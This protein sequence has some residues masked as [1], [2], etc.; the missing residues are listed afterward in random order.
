MQLNF[1]T[2]HYF[3]ESICT[4][5]SF[6][7]VI[8]LCSRNQNDSSVCSCVQHSQ[9]NKM[10]PAILSWND[11]I[12]RSNRSNVLNLRP[13]AQYSTQY[14]FDCCACSKLRHTH[15]Y[16]ASEW[17][18]FRE[19]FFHTHQQCLY[20]WCVYNLLAASSARYIA[21]FSVNYFYWFDSTALRQQSVF[22]AC[23]Y[24]YFYEFNENETNARLLLCFPKHCQFAFRIIHNCTCAIRSSQWLCSIAKVNDDFFPFQLPDWMCSQLCEYA[25]CI[26]T[27]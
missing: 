26:Q 17:R 13:C 20:A 2:L 3:G 18:Q 12:S 8:R 25:M 9:I 22:T 23:F 24:R 11:V 14:K 7:A 10:L 19:I 21:N 5:S 27:T 4:A 15:K 1:K 6:A 16:G